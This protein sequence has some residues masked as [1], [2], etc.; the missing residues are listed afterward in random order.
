M[1]MGQHHQEEEDDVIVGHQ[2]FKVVTEIVGE[3]RSRWQSSYTGR[4]VAIINK[5]SRK[6]K[7]SFH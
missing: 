2:L 1:M 3:V 5:H 7:S 4:A 6:M